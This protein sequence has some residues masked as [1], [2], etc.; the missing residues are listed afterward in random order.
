MI[1]N[2][3]QYLVDLSG[4]FIGIGL[5]LVVGIALLKHGADGLVN[6]SSNLGLRMGI[7]RVLTGLTIVAF[8]TSAP[9]LVVSTVTAI[10]G[11]PE[12]CFGN[13][14]GSNLANTAL[15]L[16]V[17]ALIAPVVIQKKTIVKE[18]LHSFL[19]LLLVLVLAFQGKALSRLDGIILLAVFTAWMTW[20]VAGAR[21]GESEDIASDV[22]FHPRHLGLDLLYTVLGL[23]GLVLG[24]NLLVEGAILSAKTMGVPDVFIGLTIVA[25][26]TS[27]PELAVSVV[28]ALEGKSDLTVGNVFGSNIFNALLI[29]GVCCTIQ[30]IEFLSTGSAISATDVSLP[31][32][33]STDLPFTALV[34]ALIIPLMAHKL[35]LSRLKGLFLL[36]LY[37]GFMA[38]L[39]FRMQG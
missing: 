21:K 5:F 31:Q 13:V 39:I 26:G 25:V 34:C 27:L 6:G 4:L 37:F 12:I 32:P 29:L 9:E 3:L 38:F 11:K 10:Q 19:S 20:L 28:A 36:A 24:A 8:G 30:P 7:S 35:T 1:S 16:G 23:T 17:S 15:I 14:I 18:G 33:L 22:V 2:L